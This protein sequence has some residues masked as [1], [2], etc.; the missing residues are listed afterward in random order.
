LRDVAVGDLESRCRVAVSE[1]ARVQF[2]YAWFPDGAA[3]SSGADG[4]EL[5]Y[6]VHAASGEPPE[7]WRCRPGVKGK[8]PHSYKG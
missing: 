3:Q 6:I 5:R 4:A 1:G 2:A 7:I 8:A